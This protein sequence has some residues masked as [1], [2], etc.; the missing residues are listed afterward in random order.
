MQQKV[1]PTIKTQT[2]ITP[3]RLAFKISSGASSFKRCNNI[4]TWAYT[5]H[6]CSGLISDV[7]RL[8]EALYGR[9]DKGQVCISI[10]HF[11][12]I[13]HRGQ[14]SPGPGLR[15]N[16]MF[17]CASDCNGDS[18]KCDIFIENNFISKY[19][20]TFYSYNKSRKRCDL[21]KVVKVLKFN[22]SK[23]P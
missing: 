12:F 1:I 11:V 9:V 18:L 8:K 3:R 21:R 19:Y 17:C 4:G 15:L 22:F 7:R 14:H 16:I 20:F 23:L 6:L 5:C 2:N 10:Q 13:L